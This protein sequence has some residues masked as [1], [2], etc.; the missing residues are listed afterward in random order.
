MNLLQM[1]SIIPLWAIV[2]GVGLWETFAAFGSPFRYG[3][4]PGILLL[5]FVCSR[6]VADMAAQASAVAWL[7]V[8]STFARAMALAVT[9]LRLSELTSSASPSSPLCSDLSSLA[10]V[11]SLFPVA[12]RHHR[13]SVLSIEVAAPLSLWLRLSSRGVSRSCPH[14]RHQCMHPQHHRRF[15]SF[16]APCVRA[17]RRKGSDDV[18]HF[19]GVRCYAQTR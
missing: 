6:Q 11:A 9:P 17:G 7:P 10:I 12:P 2:F 18:Q 19:S 3:A 16:V 1:G 5:C 15:S 4:R 8:F 13:A 14:L